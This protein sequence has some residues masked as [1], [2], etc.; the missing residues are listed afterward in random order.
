MAKILDISRENAYGCK[1]ARGKMLS[2]REME[3]K[4]TA[5][6][7]LLDC[8]TGQIFFTLIAGKNAEKLGRPYIVCQ[9]S[10]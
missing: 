4:P 10:K 9:Q 5:T 2:I 3:M 8:L 7:Y 1:R 6:A